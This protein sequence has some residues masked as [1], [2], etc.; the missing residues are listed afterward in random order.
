MV[1]QM[2]TIIAG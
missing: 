2:R 1:T